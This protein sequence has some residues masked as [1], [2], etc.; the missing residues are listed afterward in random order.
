MVVLTGW[1]MHCVALPVRGSPL[2]RLN[3]DVY[4]H[5]SMAVRREGCQFPPY[6]AAVAM[7][8][9]VARLDMEKLQDLL[10]H[11]TGKSKKQKGKTEEQHITF[12]NLDQYPYV[13]QQSAWEL[14]WDKVQALYC[15]CIGIPM[16]I[17]NNSV[18]DQWSSMASPSSPQW[19]TDSEDS[20]TLYAHA[21]LFSLMPLNLL[22]A[23]E[24]QEQGNYGNDPKLFMYSTVVIFIN[25]GQVL[26]TI[27]NTIGF[28]QHQYDA[29]LQG[30]HSNGWCTFCKL[31]RYKTSRCF[32]MVPHTPCLALPMSQPSR[33]PTV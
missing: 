6:V 28:F 22:N 17:I 3:L 11:T 10:E 31:P 13:M 1:C 5:Y 23:V 19:W 18:I 27:Q 12:K 15:P 24:G 14:D 7:D 29:I 30:G 9:K 32:P 16:F 20:N 25:P 8:E 4:V 21:V 2:S 26:T 33:D